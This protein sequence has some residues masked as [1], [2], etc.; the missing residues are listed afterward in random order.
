MLVGYRTYLVAVL[1]AVFGAL[2]VVD[3]N[4]VLSNPEAGWVA[5]A[6]AVIMAAMRAITSTPPGQG[7]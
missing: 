7:Q 1:M 3:W 6:S 4:A 2:A 5:V